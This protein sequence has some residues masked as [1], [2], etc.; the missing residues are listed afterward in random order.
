MIDPITALSLAANI[1]QFIEVG[2]NATVLLHQLW[3]ASATD[4]NNEI[5]TVSQDMSAMCVKLKG[6]SNTSVPLSKDEK[7][8]QVLASKCEVLARE[9]DSVLQGLVVRSQGAKRRVEVMQKALKVLFRADKIKSLQ[10]RLA[11]LRDQMTIRMISI[12]GSGFIVHH[13]SDLC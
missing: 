2:Y 8:L 6:A 7:K 10:K 1:V 11:E 4:E 9:L 13:R 5:E 3:D 12:L